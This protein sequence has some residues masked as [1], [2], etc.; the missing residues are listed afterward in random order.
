[1]GI[2]ELTED[3]HQVGS[4][5]AMADHLAEHDA[6]VGVAVEQPQIAQVGSGYV[7]IGHIGVAHTGKHRIAYLLDGKAAVYAIAC[8][9]LGTHHSAG[10]PR[11]QVGSAGS[12]HRQYHH[13]RRTERLHQPVGLRHHRCHI[14]TFLCVLDPL[15]HSPI[16]RG[17]RPADIYNIHR[18]TNLAKISFGV[19]LQMLKSL[20][21][22]SLR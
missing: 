2:V 19:A 5:A 15:P 7:G 8:H 6:V 1:M 13:H 12:C 3:S 16:G 9:L 17:H 14:H 21:T 20:K 22:S 18:C 4:D 10:A 11:V